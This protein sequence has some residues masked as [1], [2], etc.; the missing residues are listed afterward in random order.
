MRVLIIGPVALALLAAGC[1]SNTWTK[2]G[3]DQT[4]LSGDLAQCERQ[5]RSEATV[6]L[7]ASA[8]SS[9]ITAQTPYDSP[10]WSMTP[11]EAANTFPRMDVPREN[12]LTDECM[13]AKGYTR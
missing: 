10:R 9:V 5:A 3:A 11:S 6:P 4:M 1:A 2:S 7:S 8:G 13:Q 12:I